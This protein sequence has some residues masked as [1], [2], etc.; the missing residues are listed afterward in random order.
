MKTNFKS[1]KIIPG[2]LILCLL[3]F[4]NCSHKS[5]LPPGNDT[6]GHDEAPDIYYCPMHP[7]V[8]QDH[9]GRCPR[10]ECDGM[11]LVKKPK[12]NL[13]KTVLKPVTSNVI[14]SV[15]TVHPEAKEM[16]SDIDINGYTDF[17]LNRTHSIN[18]LFGGR[19]D[20]LYVKRKYQEITKGE[21]L[22]DIYSPELIVAQQELVYLLQ[23]DP[24]EGSLINAA[25]QKLIIMGL[26]EKQVKYISDTKTIFTLLP[27]Y[28]QWS[29][30]IVDNLNDN[31]PGAQYGSVG[32][33]RS[34]SF[35]EEYEN[36]DELMIKE[37]VYIKAGETVFKVADPLNLF[38]YLQLKPSDLPGIKL[39]QQVI[40]YPDNSGKEVSVKINFIEPF[41]SP[42]SKTIRIRVNLLNTDKQFKIGSV[43]HAK[44]KNVKKQG[45]WV[46]LSGVVNLGTESM[47]WL[48]GEDCFKATKVETGSIVDRWIEIK[49]GL[50]AND[51][52]ALQAALLY[53]SESFIKIP[54]NDDEE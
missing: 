21:R 44:I 27:V 54:E 23:N 39:N 32:E 11:E 53:D 37:G 46:P 19:L 52:I 9:P 33:M 20:K 47:V 29:G 26:D 41:I 13:L 35:G 3:L 42:G 38:L 5:E 17:D 25:E 8:Q 40:I 31:E 24:H 48:K 49:K 7:D 43:I 4:G 51:E 16:I 6:A 2:I 30:L 10:P 14:A 18:C 50:T 45:L 12:I 15:N 34:K 1:G 36:T 28:A 22:F